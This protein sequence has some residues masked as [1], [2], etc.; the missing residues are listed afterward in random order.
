MASLSHVYIYSLCY[1]DYF[2]F[3]V[4]YIIAYHEYFALL[5]CSLLLWILCFTWKT[6]H[7]RHLWILVFF[8]IET[9]WI[10]T[11]VVCAT[12][13]SPR[14]PTSLVTRNCMDPRN[15][16]VMSAVKTSPPSRRCDHPHSG[17]CHL[18]RWREDEGNVS[19]TTSVLTLVHRCC[20][21]AG[22]LVDNK[23]LACLL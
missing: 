17:T 22:L 18:S 19:F 7:T 13:L 2:V 15:T 1:H 16:D 21:L 12:R 14:S 3:S 10:F 23:V 4:F 20:L 6:S 9:P 11:D 5:S 8:R